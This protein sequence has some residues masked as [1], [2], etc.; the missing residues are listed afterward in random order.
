MPH[1]RI[2]FIALLIIIPLPFIPATAFHHAVDKPI[3]EYSGQIVNPDIYVY[4]N[5]SIN[6]PDTSM[7]KGYNII[8]SGP[9]E[10]FLNIC[11][12]SSISCENIVNTGGSLVIRNGELARHIQICNSTFNFNGSFMLRNATIKFYNDYIG[13]TAGIS[14]TRDHVSAYHSTFRNE[15][16]IYFKGIYNVSGLYQKGQPISS[17]ISEMYEYGALQRDN[18]PVSSI[19]MCL[20]YTMETSINPVSMK[21]ELNRTFTFSKNFCIENPSGKSRFIWNLSNPWYLSSFKTGTKIPVDF[22]MSSGSKLTIWD[23]SI[24]FLSNSTIN[25]TGIDHNFMVLSGTDLY[26]LSSTFTGN[27]GPL[28][29]GG[30]FNSSR[31]GIYLENCS[32]ATLVDSGFSCSQKYCG[33][34][35]SP[36]I[37]GRNSILEIWKGSHISVS[38]RRSMFE[39]KNIAFT[40]MNGNYS[41]VKEIALNHSCME[42][43]QIIG[44]GMLLQYF[45]G[46]HSYI[47][48]SYRYRI[49]GLE[50][51][52]S[53]RENTVFN[54]AGANQ[55]VYFN[56]TS[57][58]NVT[59][60]EK[61][62]STDTITY[63]DIK[64]TCGNTSA[65]SL[66]ILLNYSGKELKKNF[67]IETILENKSIC[68]EISMARNPYANKSCL[69]AMWY[70]SYNNSIFVENMSGSENLPVEQYNY[71]YNLTE[72]GVP[73]WQQWSIIVQN[74]TYASWQNTITLNSSHPFLM[75]FPQIAG[76]FGTS[77]K[78][79]KIFPGT[80]YFNYSIRFGTIEF[81]C[82]GSSKY[83]I[84]CVLFSQCNIRGN[85]SM[86]MPYGNYT[87]IICSGS[88]VEV[89][90]VCIQSNM[91]VLYISFHQGPKNYSIYYVAKYAIYTAALIGSG[92]YLTRRYFISFC[93]KCMEGRKPFDFR[94]HRCWVDEVASVERKV[95]K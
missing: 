46:N 45:S 67:N 89:K 23:S 85:Y 8:F 91:T 39:E 64:S 18:Y 9:R 25:H 20:N 72:F 80:T 76:S 82:N 13:G 27:E 73:A 42:G 15:A 83:D 61:Y 92:A 11:I 88:N 78:K 6:G 14:F 22:N 48:S 94:N 38:I 30:Y 21:F 37:K 5:L 17:N 66:R 1:T 4:G 44:S 59:L 28:F 3:L 69:N 12:N 77:V 70:I 32:R 24:C 52:L 95:E 7:F 29:N 62:T 79:E 54:Q 10:H 2:C 35:L 55:I 51:F 60:F 47:F 74:I 53:I 31:T 57:T 71:T 16:P 65:M 75:V 36:I 40:G 19:A 43:K 93:P 41:R 56:G 84:T 50:K 63:V 87:F 81:V 90:D 68:I 33:G 58:I 49:Y 86:Q 26:S 34:N